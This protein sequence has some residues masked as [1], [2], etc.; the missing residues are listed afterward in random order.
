MATTPRDPAPIVKRAVDLAALLTKKSYFLFGPRQ[1]VKATACVGIRPPDLGTLDTRRD[2]GR[3][4]PRSAARLA[5]VLLLSGLVSCAR[6]LQIPLSLETHWHP[7]GPN[8]EPP[9]KV[10][11]SRVSFEGIKAALAAGAAAR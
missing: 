7:N 5:W 11:D 9:D 3:A 1:T 2:Q 8:G 6:P 4:A 10:E